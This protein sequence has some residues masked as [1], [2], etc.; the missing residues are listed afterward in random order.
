MH[1]F[2]PSSFVLSETSAATAHETSVG[3]IRR[4]LPEATGAATAAP[5]YE[6]SVGQERRTTSSTKRGEAKRPPCTARSSPWKSC[7]VGTSSAGEDVSGDQ[8][9]QAVVE[10]AVV[11]EVRTMVKATRAVRHSEDVGLRNSNHQDLSKNHPLPRKGHGVRACR[12]SA[13]TG[14][15]K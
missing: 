4:S 5:L 8:V 6:A 7:G 1:A 10:E 3:R 9:D 11:D 15:A 2:L 13:S 12:K 14:W